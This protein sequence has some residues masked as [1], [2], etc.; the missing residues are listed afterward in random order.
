MKKFNNAKAKRELSIIGS[1]WKAAYYEHGTYKDMGLREV[2]H[3][4]S[5]AVAFAKIPYVSVE[6]V[7]EN[8]HRNGS[9]LYFD[10]GSKQK[11]EVLENGTIIQYFQKYESDEYEEKLRYTPVTEE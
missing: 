8:P 1:K 2:A 10:G 6:S 4:Q 3:V 9:W 5:N 11:F 7:K